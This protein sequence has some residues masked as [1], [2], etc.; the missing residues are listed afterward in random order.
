MFHRFAY[1][2]PAMLGYLRDQG[3]TAF[4]YRLEDFDDVRED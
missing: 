4:D 2:F 3:C 1:G